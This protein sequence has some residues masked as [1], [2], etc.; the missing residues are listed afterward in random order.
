MSITDT[1]SV[2]PRR[3]WA[4]VRDGSFG[5]FFA[6]RML[7]TVGMWSH[8]ITAAIVVFELTGSALF[9]GLVAAAQFV[10]QFLLTPWSG[11]R[12]DRKDRRRQTILGLLIAVAGS[13]G[14][15][16]WF[17]T[18]S[19]SGTSG[20]LVV[21]AASFVVGT[22][23]SIASP[24]MQAVLPALVR[25]NELAQAVALNSLTVLVG[26]AAGP[27]FGALALAKGS[28]IVGFA[29]NGLTNGVFAFIMGRIRIR[30]VHQ[31][32]AKDGSIHAAFAHLR[33]DPVIG[34]ALIG[35]AAVGIGSDPVLT[36]TPA[37]V[38]MLG[39]PAS[40]A[41]VMASSFGLGAGIAFLG[42]RALL[43][44]HGSPIVGLLGLGL[45]AAGMFGVALSPTVVIANAWM[46]LAGSGLTF[47]LTAMTTLIQERV[48]EELRGRI[49]ALWTIAWVGP[50][51]PTST[52]S[53]A[54][55][56]RVGAR[57]AVAL[58]A[59]VVVLAGLA[60]RQVRAKP[61]GGL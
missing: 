34:G 46:V 47:G 61:G 42:L 14:L 51:P 55:A 36:L 58:V 16:A 12:S 15:V 21:V 10:P 33:V 2:P 28:A 48:P 30:E 4:L 6:G 22:G 19:P 53:G 1:V 41:G 8:Q 37:F 43:R 50:R 27:A 25:T 24:P 13:I 26:R 31:P 54:V 5:P 35:I 29:L 7:A 57:A 52:L 20:A 32:R 40:S 17:A 59:A 45:I 9:V 3:A 49:M 11:A 39:E 23:Y 60:A 44:R 38:T 18:M 56:D